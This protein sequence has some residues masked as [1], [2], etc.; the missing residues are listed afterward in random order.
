MTLQFTGNGI[1]CSVYALIVYAYVIECPNFTVPQ[2][3]TALQEEYHMFA[4]TKTY[5]PH[6]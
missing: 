3:T 1:P 4:D 6:C 2:M 5:V